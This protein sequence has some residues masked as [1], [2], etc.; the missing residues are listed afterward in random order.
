MVSLGSVTLL[1][2][3][4]VKLEFELLVD[5]VLLPPAPH[6]LKPNAANKPNAVDD[7]LDLTLKIGFEDKLSFRQ[8]LKKFILP[9]LFSC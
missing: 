5:D 3:E 9:I 4:V 7:C 6:A 2:L 1:S 8:T